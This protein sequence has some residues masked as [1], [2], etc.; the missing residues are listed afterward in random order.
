MDDCLFTYKCNYDFHKG[1]GVLRKAGGSASI[2]ALK[3]II[4]RNIYQQPLNS[5]RLTFTSW[6][7]TWD[8]GW[9]DRID[10]L[11][12]AGRSWRAAHITLGVILMASPSSP[13]TL[14]AYIRR[15]AVTSWEWVRRIHDHDLICFIFVGC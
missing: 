12:W 4:A 11:R 14:A 13:T 7:Y 3:R 2:T 8:C 5:L 6:Y 1:R 15:Q 10:N 9:F